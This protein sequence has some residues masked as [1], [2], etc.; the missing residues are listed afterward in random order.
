MTPERL[1]ELRDMAI[2]RL[3][4]LENNDDVVEIL[5]YIDELEAFNARLVNDRFNDSELLQRVVDDDRKSLGGVLVLARA[6]DAPCHH[7]GCT[8]TAV[9]ISSGLSDVAG[10]Y[11]QVHADATVEEGAPE[12]MV[13]CPNCRCEFGVRR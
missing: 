4:F 2:N 13:S 12:Y 5:A 10:F 7:E 8:E 1:A 3:A 9:T 6:K 11:C